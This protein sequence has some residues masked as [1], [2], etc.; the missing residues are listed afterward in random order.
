[1]TRSPTFP[2]TCRGCSTRERSCAGPIPRRAQPAERATRDSDEQRIGEALLALVAESRRLGVDPELAVRAAARRLREQARA[3]TY[4]LPLRMG[5]IEHIH[6]R[7]I[8]DSRGNPTVEV[9]VALGSGARGRAAV[10]SGASTGE[11]EATELRDGGERWSGK[12][13]TRAVENVNG[14]IAK[15]LAGARATDQVGA[16]RHAARARRDAEQVTAGGERDPR[17]LARRRPRRGRRGGGAALP[18]HRR[19]LRL[20]ARAGDGAAGADDERDQRRRPRRQRGRPPGVHGRPGR[21][22]ELRRRRC[23]PAP[24]SFTR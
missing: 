17:C 5:A 11:F 8:L 20:L 7:Q 14:E 22:G 3:P 9:E 15:A 18:L 16:R 2:R 6:A 4:S 23:G 19:A 12:G 1:M 13:V 10:P 21:R 24:R